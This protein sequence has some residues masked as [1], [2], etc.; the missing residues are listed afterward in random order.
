MVKICNVEQKDQN[1]LPKKTTHY[2]KTHLFVITDA[3]LAAD[4]WSLALPP[5]LVVEPDRPRSRT[6]NT[7]G[8]DI[9]SIRLH[10]PWCSFTASTSKLAP[11]LAALL[12]AV[13][14]RLKR[15]CCCRDLIFSVPLSAPET[16]LLLRTPSF[17]SICNTAVSLDVIWRHLDI[18]SQ[19]SKQRDYLC[20]S[21]IVNLS[22][23]SR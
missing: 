23:D 12:A 4:A 16:E 3:L 2:M 21:V 1:I 17:L 20:N 19:T 7:I 10:L 22:F 5:V 8:C 11:E 13:L 6:L 9:P 15:E 18:S 14:A